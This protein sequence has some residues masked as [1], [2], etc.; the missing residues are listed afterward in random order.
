MNSD[1]SNLQS[2]IM[3]STRLSTALAA[4]LAAITLSVGPALAQTTLYSSG[5]KTWD[6]TTANWGTASGGPYTTAT[7]TSG[8]NA[9]F[10]GTV[11]TVT[12]GEAISVKDLRFTAAASNYTIA[13]NTLNFASGGSITQSVKN[14]VHAITAPITGSPAVNVMDGTGYEGLNFA[15]NSGSQTLGTC[16][17]PYE[18][19][20]GDKAGMRLGGTTTGNSV[21]K[22]QYASGN[23]WG[24]VRKEG[25][26]TWS[27]G[28]V[29][30]GILYIDA[31]NLIANGKITT[32]YQGTQLNGGILHYNNNAA[33]ANN[34]QLKG[35]SLDNT[36]GAAITTSTTNS[37]QSWSASW[38][39]LGSNGALS[40]LT[41]GTG[42]VTLGGS[43]TV[44]V[45][46]A[47]ATLTVGGVISDGTS[48][49]SL[50]KAG[51]GT[52]RLTG[53]NSYNGAT[54][55]NEGTLSITQ[56]YLDDNATVSVAAGATL[57]LDFSGTDNV[58][59]LILGGSPAAAGEWGA[60]GSGAANESAL[61]TGSGRLNNA[62][63][64]APAGTWYWDGGNVSIGTDGD[65]VGAGGAGIWSTAVANWDQGYTSHK[66]WNNTTADTAIFKTTGGAVDLQSDITLGRILVDGT[67][68]YV[69]GS[70]P[71]TQILN[72]GGATNEIYV[73]QAT[74]TIRAGITG[75][76]K[77]VAYCSNLYPVYLYPDAN[78]MTL[79]DVTI[80]GAGN[81]P[82]IVLGGSTTGNSIA[83]VINANTWSFLD[84][85]GAGTWTLGDVTCGTIRLYNGTL[86]I[87]G[88]FN[89][90]NQGFQWTTGT[91]KGA[92]TINTAVTVPATGNLFPG[93]PVGTLSITGTLDISAPANGG[94]GKLNFDLGPIEGSDKI[95][96]AGTLNIGSGKLGL[97]DFVF[98][99]LGGTVDGT[100]TLITTTG[101]ITGTLDPADRVGTILGHAGA[102]QINGNNLEF[103]SDSDGDGIPDA[104]ELAYT[105][106]PS[107]TAMTPGGDLDNDGL[108]NMQEYVSGTLPNNPDT[109]GDT[110]T[111]GAEVAGAGARPP[112]DPLKADTDGDGLYDDY[113]SNTGT[114]VDAT[115]T[116]TNPTLVDTD[117]DALRDGVETNT[118]TYFSSYDTGTNPLVSDSDGDGATDWYEVAASFTDPN[119]NT[120]KPNIPYP[121]PDPDAST[122]VTN[123]PVKVYIMSGQSNMVGMGDVSGTA[124]GLLDTITK[125]ENKFPNLLNVGNGWTTR[126]DVLYKGVI[127]DTWAG[128]LTVADGSIGPE[129]GFG[130]VMGWY[131]D[132]PVLLIKSSIGNRA[133]G[134]D[135]RPPG[136]PQYDY[137]NGYTY[138]AYGG[139]PERWL[140]GTTSVP[141]GWCAGFQYDQCFLNE[142]DMSPLALASGAGG[143]NVVDILDSFATNYPQWAAQGFEIAGYVWWQGNRDIGT[144]PPYT[145]QYEANMVQFIKQLRAY[146]ANRYPGKCS[147]TTTPFVLATGCG[148][149]QTSGNGLVVAN[150]QLAVSDPAKHPEFA[151]NVKTMDIRPYWRDVAVSPANQGHHYN[152][153]AETYMLVGDALGRGMIEL[154]AGGT[155]TGFAAWQ[156]ANGAAGQ[157]LADD[158]DGDGVS[159][160]IEWFLKGSNN[161]SG[162]T[163][164]PG[165]SNISGALSITWTK[166]AGYTGNY[167]THFVVETSDSLT[168][169]WTSETSPGP[170]TITGNEVKYTFPAPLGAKKFARLKVTGP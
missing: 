120:A 31:G 10:E 114:W 57:N 94:S 12:L 130:H 69:I 50:S 13:G 104:Y 125:R 40:D 151:G 168:G 117:V 146:Y 144:G 166:D 22:I 141:I 161:S 75:S 129:L 36:S 38:T 87:N 44:T 127:S 145:E 70:N 5:P 83:K 82:N 93:N 76:P 47:A 122:G 90:T 21:S 155:T 63:G 25:S 88:T 91:L 96:V 60:P 105:D 24:G 35:G 167:G 54:T 78:S 169:T 43:Y 140:T 118:G 26:G 112:T 30:I 110:L 149:P 41:L 19:G 156:S 77:L 165:V 48:S 33:V 100:Y 4:A 64:L 32:A 49:F 109:D 11:G 2:T 119:S 159:N 14:A 46:N 115:N 98:T 170:V 121:L 124:P 73:N 9:T 133:L 58:F 1:L 42:A 85:D 101:G 7:W 61:L 39:F 6:A 153:N 68:N 86:V 113:E 111:D 3:K 37:P 79:G 160:G 55:V 71:E 123:K 29:N 147:A 158:H 20:N 150:A 132:E 62:G 126:Y 136:S 18:G 45:Q 128:N 99:D 162:F 59:Y 72:F 107:A 106:P 164:L 134:W 74:T 102:L 16:T 34:F 103:S 23:Q 8:S 152:R 17:I 97:S 27:V 81:N 148:D 138:P 95:A 157:T 53:F 15:P 80:G 84:K 51:A 89:K 92:G 142:A 108:T 67:S 137:T 66:V 163:A 56:K 139:S 28:D 154:E 143:T 135:F 52:L 131:H 65:G 116:G